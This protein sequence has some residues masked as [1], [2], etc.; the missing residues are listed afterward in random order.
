M[1]G[2]YGDGGVGAGEAVFDSFNAPPPCDGG[3]QP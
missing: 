1:A 3:T 2:T